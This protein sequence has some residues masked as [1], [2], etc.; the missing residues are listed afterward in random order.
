[1]ILKQNIGV[2]GSISIITALALATVVIANECCC[3]TADGCNHN[4]TSCLNCRVC[5][6]CRDSGSCTMLSCNG[7]VDEECCKYEAP[8]SLTC[9]PKPAEGPCEQGS[10]QAGG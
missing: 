7:D 8:G 6:W 4:C 10:E 9:V 3:Y 1:M 5:C 2:V